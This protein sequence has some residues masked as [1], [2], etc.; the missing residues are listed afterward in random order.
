MFYYLLQGEKDNLLSNAQRDNNNSVDEQEKQRR[1]A[2]MEK[3]REQR[4]RKL[5]QWKVSKNS[6]LLVKNEKLIS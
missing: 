3:E 1:K 2:M 5:K 4:M 6:S